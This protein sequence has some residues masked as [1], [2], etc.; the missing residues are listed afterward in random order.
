MG[1]KERRDAVRRDSMM[2]GQL[3]GRA[4][5]RCMD[6]AE[7]AVNREG[8]AMYWTAARVMDEIAPL[9]V[10]AMIAGS[11]RRC[12]EV[13][14]D[15]EIV[16]IPTPQEDM[17]GQAVGV[18]PDFCELVNSWEKVKGEPT[19]KYT[20]RILPWFDAKLDL[21]MVTPQ[22]WGLQVAIRTG[23]ADFSHRVLAR[24]WTQLGYQ[25]EGGVLQ[26]DGH[27]FPLDDERDVFELLGIPWVDPWERN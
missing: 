13:P 19:G 25:S 7:R 17:F 20:Q 8:L 4:F 12:K 15:I 22:S 26:K 27:A 1:H 5:L 24:R 11:V 2:S 14:G 18:S 6:W 3:P 10:R 9:C 23:S 16:C 21:F